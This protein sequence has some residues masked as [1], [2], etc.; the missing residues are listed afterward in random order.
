MDFIQLI[1]NT[2]EIIDNSGVIDMDH[3]WFCSPYHNK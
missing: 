2:G 3:A 1:Q